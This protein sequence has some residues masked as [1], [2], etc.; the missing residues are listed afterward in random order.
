MIKNSQKIAGPKVIV[1]IDETLVYKIKYIGRLR[2]QSWVIGGICPLFNTY[3]MQILP[4][5]NNETIKNALNRWIIPGNIIYIDE[6]AVYPNAINVFN[7][8][9]SSEP[10]SEYFTVN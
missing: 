4:N 8:E 3:F 7:E 5:K 9:N 1:K 6:W 10:D 2:E